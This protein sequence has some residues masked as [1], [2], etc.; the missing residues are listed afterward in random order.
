MVGDRFWLAGRQVCHHLGRGA[1]AAAGR[2]CFL[3]LLVIRKAAPLPEDG[4][5]FGDR[6]GRLATECCHLLEVHVQCTL[7]VQ[8][9]KVG[10]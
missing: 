8:R 2:I 4:Y 9:T 7:E 10:G 6:V 5:R 3:P 1:E